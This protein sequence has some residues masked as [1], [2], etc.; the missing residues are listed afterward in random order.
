MSGV[1]HVGEQPG[2]CN[3]DLQK[4]DSIGKCEV[5]IVKG[6]AIRRSYG[7]ELYFQCQ[8]MKLSDFLGVK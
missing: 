3:N 6:G 4:G 1:V 8:H 2:A 5:Q 7:G